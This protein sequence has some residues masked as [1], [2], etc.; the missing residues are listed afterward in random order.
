LDAVADSEA[1]FARLRAVIRRYGVLRLKGLVALPGR[2]R[3]LVVQALGPPLQQ[4]FDLPW[5]DGDSRQSRL[6]VV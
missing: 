2:A 6:V 5:P 1:F 3:R 4:Y